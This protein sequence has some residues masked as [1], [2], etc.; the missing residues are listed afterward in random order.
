MRPSGDVLHAAT[1]AVMGDGAID[2]PAAHH[3]AMFGKSAAMF[4]SEASVDQPTARLRH[5]DVLPG[6]W[7]NNGSRGR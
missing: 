6:A 2:P 3:G 1:A 4:V 5:R 7:N